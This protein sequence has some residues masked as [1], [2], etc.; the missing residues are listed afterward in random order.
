MNRIGT[1]F[2]GITGGGEGYVLISFA[3]EVSV[4]FVVAAKVR[5]K[6]AEIDVGIYG[7]VIGYLWYLC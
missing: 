2:D 3:R 4:F 5:R 6:H 7:M 1:A